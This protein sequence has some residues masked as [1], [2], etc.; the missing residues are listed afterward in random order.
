MYLRYIWPMSQFSTQLKDKSKN[1][2]AYGIFRHQLT[3][4]INKVAFQICLTGFSS[5]ISKSIKKFGKQIKKVES[6]WRRSWVVKVKKCVPFPIIEFY[7]SNCHIASQTPII[8]DLREKKNRG[9]RKSES[10][11][12]YSSFEYRSYACATSSCVVLD[13]RHGPR[14]ISD[15]SHWVVY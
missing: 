4:L 14:S 9:D 8:G 13:H 1:A 10:S 2:H 7:R 11:L 3:S 15:Q 6:V 5:S 12:L